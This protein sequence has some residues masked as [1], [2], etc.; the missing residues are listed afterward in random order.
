M[1]RTDGRWNGTSPRENRVSGRIACVC[2]GV[3]VCPSVSSRLLAFRNTPCRRSRSSSTLPSASLSALS[4]TC[5]LPRRP[6]RS[7][8]T[9]A[10]CVHGENVHYT[11]SS[12]EHRLFLVNP[13]RG[14]RFFLIF[15]SL[16]H[17]SPP[18]GLGAPFRNPKF[19]KYACSPCFPPRQIL[20]IS[21]RA[22]PFQL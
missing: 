21:S 13:L 5:A 1:G 2:P 12:S 10:I 3:S 16:K 15:P 4:R 17:P 9:V 22:R 7:P 8:S 14:R 11:P 20:R 6:I 18:K 19:L